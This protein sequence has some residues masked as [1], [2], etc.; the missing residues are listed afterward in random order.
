MTFGDWVRETKHRYQT[1][2][3]GT[4]TRNSARKFLVG[5]NRR[6]IDP[7]LGNTWWGDDWDVLVVLDAMRVDQ[8][9][10][11]LGDEYD[12]R[13]RWSAASTSI[14]WIE[15]HFDEQHREH[16]RNTAYVTGNPFASNQS[17]E[18]SSADLG[19]KQ[20]GY[21]DAVYKDGFTDLENGV[22][23]TPPETMTKRAIR[24]AR[25]SGCDR[26]IVHYMQPHQP[27]RSKP[28]W[29]GVYSN[30]E[31]LVR[32]V[33]QGGADI[34]KRCRDG[35]I[36]R[37]ELWNA[38]CDNLRW[39]WDDVSQNLLTNVDGD[40]IVT[41][42]HGNGMGEWGFWSH[43]GGQITPQIRKVPYWRVDATDEHTI[44]GTAPTSNHSKS[45]GEQLKALGY[46]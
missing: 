5:A 36:D 44:Q 32:D 20:L 11:V 7:H 18:A 16:Y 37:D 4:A 21:F 12:I 1:Q 26:L 45:T 2:S 25:H 22:S 29:D 28:E 19:E 23:T 30:L 41:A 9:R 43:A 31:N 35:E 24:A 39:V 38:Y 8:A 42:D 46:K 14:D 15:R 10:E 33:N 13:S 27:F 6:V 34:W 17:P 3:V 40:V